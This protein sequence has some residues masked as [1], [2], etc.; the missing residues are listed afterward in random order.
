MGCIKGLQN[1]NITK[2]GVARSRL[3]STVYAGLNFHTAI[4]VKI[5][6]G[7]T[8]PCGLSNLTK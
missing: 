2:T 3:D 1:K 4:F 8:I 7:I 5:S 6:H